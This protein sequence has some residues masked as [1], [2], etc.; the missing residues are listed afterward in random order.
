MEKQGE[1]EMICIFHNWGRWEDVSTTEKTVFFS[2]AGSETV[3]N[4]IMQR[5]RCA[6][7]NKAQDRR[8]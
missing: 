6:R 2:M 3:T 8:P 5:R 1:A 4:K 7:C